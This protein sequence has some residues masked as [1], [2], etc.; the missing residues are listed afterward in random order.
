MQ[1]VVQMEIQFGWWTIS[2]SS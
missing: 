1:E 2:C